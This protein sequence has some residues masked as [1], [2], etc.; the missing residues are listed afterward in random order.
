MVRNGD[1]R[2]DDY[3]KMKDRFRP[4]HADFTYEAKYGIRNW[5]GGGRASARETTARVMAGVIAKKFLKQ[6][7]GMEILAY[8][9]Q[10]GEMRADIDPEKVTLKKVEA[11]VVRCPDVKLAK[12]MEA[13]IKTVQKD[14][15]TVGGVVGCVVKKVPVGLGEPVFGKLKAS[16]AQAMMSLPATMGVEFGSGFDCLG[17][18]GSEHND[19]FDVD[20]GGRQSD[21]SGK[22]GMPKKGMTANIITKTNNSGGIQGGISN[23]MPITFRTVFKPV[24]TIFKEQDTVTNKGKKAKI[25]MPGRHDPCVVPRAVVMVEAMTALVLVDYYLLSRTDRIE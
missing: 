13:Y 16:L 4:S 12:Q 23:G 14:G 6:S 10:V 3:K 22:F 15:D 8:V 7:C 17:M 9:D 18:R 24:S 11:N 1:A 20:R 21:P 19:V 5:A 2:P 25:V